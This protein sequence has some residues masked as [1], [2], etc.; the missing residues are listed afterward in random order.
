MN[1]P[2]TFEKLLNEPASVLTSNTDSSVILKQIDKL[3]NDLIRSK[4]Q[5]EHLNDLLNESELNN[6][7]LTEQINVLKEEIRRYI[8]SITRF[9]SLF[10]K[11]IE[12]RFK[13]KAWAKSRARKVHLKYGVPQKCR[14]EVFDV[15]KCS[16][17]SSTP[18]SSNRI[19]KPHVLEA[20]A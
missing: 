8:Y 19:Y 9:F 6:V 11:L 7:R 15:F 4:K 2:N 13:L 16:G 3:K 1:S 17:K 18:A 10:I 5:L 14:V 20:I 12:I